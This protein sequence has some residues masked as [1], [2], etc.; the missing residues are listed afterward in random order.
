MQLISKFSEG[1]RF[2]GFRLLLCVIDF[3]SKY[4]WV[5]LLKDKKCIMITKAFSKISDE[6][7]RKPSKILVNQ[8]REFYNRT[9]KSFL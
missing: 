5:F 9:S 2:H 4:P 7:K 6:S 8:D 1:F 3:Y